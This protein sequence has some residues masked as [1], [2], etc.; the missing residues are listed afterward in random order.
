M[1]K[2]IIIGIIAILGL[3][4]LTGCN[5]KKALNANDFVDLV[6]QNN[7]IT[8]N[9]IND[10]NNY[11]QIKSAFIIQN[12][13]MTYQIEYYELDTVE[14]T[15]TFYEGNIKV[16]KQQENIKK[17]NKVETDNYQKYTQETDTVYSFISRIDNTIIYLTVDMKYKDEVNK[18]IEKI[19]Y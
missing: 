14:N 1:K 3:F 11:P 8:T 19:G 2:K 4:T 13:D 12:K 17:K 7:Y 16:F 18:L 6:E 9:I 5:N 15:K 10:F